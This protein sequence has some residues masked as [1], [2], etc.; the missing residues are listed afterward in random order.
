MIIAA[1]VLDVLKLWLYFLQTEPEGSSSV[2]VFYE[3]ILR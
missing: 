1:M 3:S 2:H